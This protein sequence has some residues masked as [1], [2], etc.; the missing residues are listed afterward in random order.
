MATMLL[1]GLWHGAAWNY[2]LWGG[3]QGVLLCV[4]RLFGGHR[5]PRGAL[6]SGAEAIEDHTLHDDLAVRPRVRWWRRLAPDVRVPLSIAFFFLFV[7]YGWLLFRANS[8]TQ[9]A[10][11]TKT[12]C[13]FGPHDLPSI[14][15]RPV[16]PAL[17]GVPLLFAL[18]ALEYRDGRPDM[19]RHW[20]RPLQG[21]VYAAMLLIL[22]LGMSNAPVQFIYFQF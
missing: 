21:T 22:T 11:F 12:L 15:P 9:I 6:P 20:P 7:C 10:A 5:R 14:L 1:G 4:H 8:F 2:V 16:L 13:G 18:Q 3:Y 17:I 19:L